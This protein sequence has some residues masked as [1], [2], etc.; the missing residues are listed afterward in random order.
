MPAEV[1]PKTVLVPLDGSELSELSLPHAASVAT[2]L[3]ARIALLR[4]TATSDF[5]RLYLEQEAVGSGGG[6]WM[7]A[8]E[9]VRTDSQEAQASLDRA[10]RRLAIEF[11][12]AHEVTVCHL[13]GQNPAEAIVEMAA[14]EPT[15]VVM[16][17][18]GRSGINRLVLGSVTDRVV[19]HANAPVLVVR[20]WD[21]P[22]FTGVEERVSQGYSAGLGNAAAQRA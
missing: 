4:V 18:H 2:A 11:G 3:G 10:K 13:Q 7:S 12:F 19:R 22:G 17:T 8:D 15:L 5:Y 1:E 20:K 16:T 6:E 9:L 14:A 21:E